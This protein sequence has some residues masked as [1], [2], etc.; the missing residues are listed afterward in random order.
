MKKTI[1]AV[2]AVVLTTLSACDSGT[3]VNV[4]GIAGGC[5]G[6]KPNGLGMKGPEDVKIFAEGLCL[7]Q[8]KNYAVQGR[9]P[10]G[11]MQI[12]QQ[13]T[14]TCAMGVAVFSRRYRVRHR[15]SALLRLAP[16]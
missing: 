12:A 5:K 11:Q 7:V 4:P 6:G 2:T 9:G 10:P 16:E 8:Q 3:W 13:R 15:C 14:Y 1:L